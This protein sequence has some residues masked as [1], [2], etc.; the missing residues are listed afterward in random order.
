M[1]ITQKNPPVGAQRR[2][3]DALIAA[4]I[5]AAGEWIAVPV[6]A[7][8][9]GRNRYQKQSSIYQAA[10]GRNVRVQTTVQQNEIFI[11]L[12]PEVQHA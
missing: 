9:A 1:T 6:D 5:A 7:E 11:R 8:I 4:V 12:L 10:A 3:Y 2:R